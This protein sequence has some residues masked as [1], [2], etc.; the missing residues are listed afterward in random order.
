MGIQLTPGQE[1]FFQE[2]IDETGEIFLVP[3]LDGSMFYIPRIGV[4]ALIDR[5]LAESLREDVGQFNFDSTVLE[6]VGRRLSFPLEWKSA[7]ATKR[8]VEATW[9]PVTVTFSNTQKCTLRCRY[10]YAD[11]GRLDDIDIDLNVARAAI[12]LVVSNAK[13]AGK[14]P[15]ITFL[16]EGE[17]TA[18][19]EGFCAIIDYFRQRCRDE[20]LDPMIH[21][22]TNG[23]FSST[24][25]DYIAANC[26]EI[27]F[28]V[29]GVAS[30]HNDNRVLPNGRGSFAKV[31][32]TMAEFDRR[33][34][35]YGIR[36][37]ATVS[38]TDSLP[39]FIRWVGENT[40]CR[41]VHVEPVFNMNGVAKTAE[42]T[43]H[44][45]AGR[46]TQA[47]RESRQIAAS[48]GI[49]LYYSSADSRM[50]YTFCGAS[51]ATNFLVTSRGIVTSCNEVM[52]PD[53]KRAS[54]FQYGKWD[55][56]T[57]KFIFDAKVIEGLRRLNVQEI[58]KCQGC[59]AKY[60][61]AGD[62]YAKTTVAN[63]DPWADGYT[64]RCHVTRELLKDY[65]AI[66]LLASSSR[67]SN[68]RSASA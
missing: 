42:A 52:R 2:A 62:C 55:Q 67:S 1:T 32:E 57:G 46:F 64:E 5:N 47:Y 7:L 66:E 58:P 44:P 3:Y 26:E 43:A 28:S 14:R 54:L 21:L 53:D 41:D 20:S 34:K 50:K 12:D 27:T 51:D 49:E 56:T 18:N 22:S 29:D 30:A 11:G 16:G 68:P 59:F 13:A 60:N 65:L 39:E 37:T 40:A 36:A 63:G 33:G 8:A 19:W 10:C 23:V 17:A 4:L 61:C 35:S 45:E 15:R 9:A 31:A 25:I 6:H 38:A 24:K 48:F